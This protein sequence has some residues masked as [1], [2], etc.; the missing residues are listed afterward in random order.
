MPRKLSSS[1]SI[2]VTVDTA[3]AAYSDGDQLGTLREIPCAFRGTE[4]ASGVLQSLVL[5]DASDTKPA[6]DI[7]I[8]S[9]T[10]TPTSG[11][12]DAAS[13]TDTIMKASFLGVIH[14]ATTDWITILAGGGGNAVAR[15]TPSLPVV[16]ESQ[17]SSLYALFVNRTAVTHVASGIVARFG[18]LQD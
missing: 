4:K 7:L 11:D 1:D 14:V 17:G 9:Q 15:L 13:V 2:K 8:F 5:V 10:I 6:L 12:N 18:M 3:A 16:N